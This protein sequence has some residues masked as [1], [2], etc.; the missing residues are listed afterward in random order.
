MRRLFSV[1]SV[2]ILGLMFA[3]CAVPADYCACDGAASTN[4]AQ[5]DM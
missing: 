4:V 3:G 1:V 2:L 5:A